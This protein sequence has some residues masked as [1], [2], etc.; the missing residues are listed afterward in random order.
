M[1]DALDTQGVLLLTCVSAAGTEL[2]AIEVEHRTE[3]IRANWFWI[4]QITNTSECATCE[5]IYGSCEFHVVPICEDPDDEMNTIPSRRLDP[6]GCWNGGVND[7]YN[8]FLYDRYAQH[9][10]PGRIRFGAGSRLN[11]IYILAA[12]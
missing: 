3:S 5:G 10:F 12:V 2:T 9:H 4:K 1:S 7:V 6:C 11:C 8:S